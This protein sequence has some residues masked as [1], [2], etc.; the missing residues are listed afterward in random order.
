MPEIRR[1]GLGDMI[2][3]VLS[4]LGIHPWEGCQCEQRKTALNRVR[5]YVP[6]YVR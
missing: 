3:A 1:I 2:E 6:V 5:L 4:F